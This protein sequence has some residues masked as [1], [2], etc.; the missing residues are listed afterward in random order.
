MGDRRRRLRTTLLIVVGVLSTAI[1]LTAYL[2]DVLQ[3]PELDTVDAR[4]S[5][6][7]T[8]PRPNDIVVVQI[9]DVTFDELDERWPFPR[10]FHARVIDQLTKA[11][12]KVIAYDVQFTEPSDDARE[13]NALIDSVDRSH[14]VVLTTT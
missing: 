8:Q 11:G 12:A 7:G 13:D 6:R 14:D 1:A 4:F 9:D 3:Q 10:S 2:T 5:I